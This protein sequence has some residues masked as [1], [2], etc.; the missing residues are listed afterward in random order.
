[1]K[2]QQ[3]INLEPQISDMYRCMLDYVEF[4]EMTEKE[5]KRADLDSVD[6][7]HKHTP[8]L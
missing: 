5:F 7:F 4:L 8:F 6:M 1:M 2:A 3:I